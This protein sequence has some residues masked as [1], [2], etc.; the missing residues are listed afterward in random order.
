MVGVM[1][2]TF[3]QAIARMEGFYV[4]GSRANRNNNPGNLNF[5]PWQSAFGAVLET[6]PAGIQE[7]ARFGAYPTADA[8]FAAMRTLLQHDYLGLT[9]SAAL[10]KW[11]P[12]SDGNDVSSY[13]A[14][15]C[16]MTGMQPTDV[17][18]A[19]NIG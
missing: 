6:I 7:T 17:L 8:G 15:V 11:A 1:Q 19:E 12:P 3:M 10:N 2:L 5:A 16:E 14:G 13:Q 18:T 9:V 4:T